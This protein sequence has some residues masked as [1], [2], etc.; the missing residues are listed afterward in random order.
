MLMEKD[1][2]E[3]PFTRRLLEAG[4]EATAVSAVYFAVG[5]R[6]AERHPVP[7]VAIEPTVPLVPFTVW[8][9]LPGYAALF[10]FAVG[11]VRT[12]ARFRRALLAFA[13]VTAVAVALFVAHPI[14][15]PTR[16][17]P[18]GDGPTLA[19][20]TWLYANDPSTNAFPSLHVANVVLCVGMISRCAPR[21]R[22]AAWI[23]GALI[24]ASTLTTRQ[25]WLGD[26]LAGAVLGAAGF[27][28]W[29]AER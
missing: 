20:L 9:Y 18:D 21:A 5:G 7:T 22:V 4:V 3:L 28:W 12:R 14:A 6:A 17:A 19:L 16:E 24:V 11:V 10:L 1:V 25:H 29:R 26:A 13:G 2:A 8:L 27:A 23:L 15:G